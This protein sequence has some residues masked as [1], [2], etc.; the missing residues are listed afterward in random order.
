MDRRQ[1]LLAALEAHEP[2]LAKIART[3]DEEGAPLA[4][5]EEVLT[6]RGI[7]VPKPAPAVETLAECLVTIPLPTPLAGC[8]D[9]D[10]ATL[11]A[12]PA[13]TYE[14]VAAVYRKY[15]DEDGG[16]LDLLREYKPDPKAR[17]VMLLAA[18]RQQADMWLDAK[19][20]GAPREPSVLLEEL[21]RG[22]MLMAQLDAWE[23]GQGGEARPAAALEPQPA[24]TPS[25]V[26]SAAAVAAR[27]RQALGAKGA[28]QARASRIRGVQARAREKAAAAGEEPNYKDG[29]Y[30]PMPNLFSIAFV[31]AMP[32]PVAKAY[33]VA[34]QLAEDDG[35]FEISHST[36]AE[37]IGSKYR[38]HGE[39]AMRR[40]VDAGLVNQR[41]RGG[42]GR[43][44][45][46]RLASLARL[47][48]E[49]AKAVLNQ[50]LTASGGSKAREPV[51]PA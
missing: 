15:C 7:P 24:T 36:L 22:G 49:T 48:V 26:P 40:L 2:Q 37:R 34:C 16:Q 18:L 43:P 29:G 23:S 17:R 45:G 5:L 6:E 3:M 20:A 39:R 27:E 8:S 31:A 42:P 25:A 50:P 11:P 12:R 51:H 10:P 28:Q 4:R 33:I 21:S 35:S 13:P 46:Y 30:R 44:N 47:D 19:R 14:Q 1:Q 32:G 41:W 9:A 38:S